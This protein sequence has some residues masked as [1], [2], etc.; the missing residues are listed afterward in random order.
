MALPHRRIHAVLRGELRPMFAIAWPVA[1][2]E[3]GWMA[4]GLVDT[5]VVGRVSAEAI[6]AVSIGSAVF[7][8]VAIFGLGMLLGLDFAVAHAFGGGRLHDARVA[9]VHGLYLSAVLS[10]GLTALLFAL[11]PYLPVLGIRPAVAGLAAPYLRALT[12]SLA[13]LLFYA[14]LRR[15]LQALGLVRAVMVALVSA[16]AINFI[17]NWMLVF[18]H[19]GFPALGAEGSGWATTISRVYLLL[20]LLAVTALHERRA[21]A[22]LRL[23]WRFVGERFASLVRLGLPAALQMLLEVGVFATAT[24]LTGR[25]ASDKLAA[26]QIALGAAA[27]TF[28]VPLGI[29]SAAAVRVGHAMGRVDPQGAARAGWAALLLGGSFMAIAAVAFIKFPDW[30]I[31]IFTTDPIVVDTGVTLLGV[32]AIFQLFDGLQVVATGALRGL[33][34]TR[35]PMVANLVGHWLIGLPIGYALCFWLDRGVV[36]LWTGL[37]TGLVSVALVL[38][39]VWSWRTNTI[40]AEYASRRAA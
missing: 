2:A 1:T 22:G 18:G 32:A 14:A 36:G 20:F 17:G 30:I 24:L 34:D 37:C 21:G 31:R 4:M 16:N 26:H 28:M 40:A 13:P 25:L 29:S 27:F 6:G 5:M 8:A 9:L 35:A 39:A 12:W 11:P 23:P 10:I 7:F 33:G 15:Y 19:L 3:L 38:I